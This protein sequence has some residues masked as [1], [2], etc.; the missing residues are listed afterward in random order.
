MQAPTFQTERLNVFALW[1]RV[2]EICPASRMFYVGFLK[3][4]DYPCHIVTATVMLP[5]EMPCYLD[6]IETG[7]QHRRRGYARE[8]V[9]GIE[10]SIGLTL[11]MDGATEAGEAFVSNYESRR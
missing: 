1:I 8:L 2:S 5:T 11:T 3:D 7:E 4:E 9:T 6:W 10:R